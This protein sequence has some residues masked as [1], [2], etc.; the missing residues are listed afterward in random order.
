MS[1]DILFMHV[2]NCNDLH[3][4]D[5]NDC[6]DLHTCRLAVTAMTDVLLLS[7]QDV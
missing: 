5:C 2:S 1:H 7:S 4:S 3:V 6:N